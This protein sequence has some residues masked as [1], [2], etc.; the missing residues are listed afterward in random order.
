MRILGGTLK[1]RNF[2]MPQSIRP[3]Q[4]LTRKAIFDLLGQ[5]LSGV[6]FLDLFAGSGSVGIEAISRGAKRVVFVERDLKCLEV[7]EKNTAILGINDPEVCEIKRGDVFATIKLLSRAKEKFD[8]IFLDPPYN[9][10]LVKKTLKTLMGY[11]ILQPN[12]LIIVEHGGEEGALEVDERFVSIKQRNY[13]LSHIEIF[14][15]K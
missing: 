10:G 15:K 4:D 8:I 2:Y 13:G 3:T 6:I 12:C 5:D 9:E 11:D 7:L 1:G 14:Q